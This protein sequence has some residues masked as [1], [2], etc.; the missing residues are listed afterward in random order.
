[1]RALLEKYEGAHDI[2]VT[3]AGLEDAFIALTSEGVEV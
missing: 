3:A 1:L 2:E